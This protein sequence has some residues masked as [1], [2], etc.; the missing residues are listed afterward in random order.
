MK[1]DH[2]HIWHTSWN[3][4]AVA[5]DSVFIENNR[6]MHAKSSAAAAAAASAYQLTGT[7]FGTGTY[8]GV[9]TCTAASRQQHVTSVACMHSC[10]RS[11]TGDLAVS[12]A[13]MLG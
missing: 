6:D 8:T 2:R 13:F 5:L 11:K 1:L 3:V 12:L 10:P 9:G 4:H 7:G